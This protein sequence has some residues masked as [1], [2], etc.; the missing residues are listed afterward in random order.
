MSRSN[1]PTPLIPALDDL[2]RALL[3]ERIRLYWI[4]K[5]IRRDAS[6]TVVHEFFDGLRQFFWCTPVHPELLNLKK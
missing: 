6:L 3:L 4:N 2:A 5:W 1:A